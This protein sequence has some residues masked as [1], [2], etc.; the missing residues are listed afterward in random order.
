LCD[1][2]RN[3]RF[4]SILYIS[5]VVCALPILPPPPADHSIRSNVSKLVNIIY[6]TFSMQLYQP[7]RYNRRC[8][9]FILS[10]ITRVPPFVYTHIHHSNCQLLWRCCNNQSQNTGVCVVARSTEQINNQSSSY[11]WSHF[12]RTELLPG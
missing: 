1:P 6:K 3:E 12:L 9:V 11:R 10:F 4:T 5:L 2:L 7:C 8:N